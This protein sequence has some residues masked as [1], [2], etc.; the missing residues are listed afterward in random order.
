MKLPGLSQLK[1]WAAV[2]FGFA[3]FILIAILRGK[4]TARAQ[5]ELEREKKS[6]KAENAALEADIRGRT[7][8]DEIRKKYANNTDRFDIK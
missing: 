5:R 3:T 1:S 7:R 6:R 2:V 8:E 4:E